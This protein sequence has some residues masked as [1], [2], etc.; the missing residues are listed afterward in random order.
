MDLWSSLLEADTN[1][2]TN[3]VYLARLS[4]SLSGTEPIRIDPEQGEIVKLYRSIHHAIDALSISEDIPTGTKVT[5]FKPKYDISIDTPSIDECPYI[6]ILDEVWT[7]GSFD[8]EVVD[9]YMIIDNRS[10]Q[11]PFDGGVVTESIISKVH[12][13]SSAESSADDSIGSMDDVYESILT[14]FVTE[15]DN[16]DK[17]DEEDDDKTTRDT[18]R[19]ARKDLNDDLGDEEPLDEEQSGEIP[20][21][22]EDGEDTNADDTNT[23]DTADTQDS[24]EGNEEGSDSDAGD[25]DGSGTGDSDSDGMDDDLGDMDESGDSDGGDSSDV[26]S[27]G[28]S[29]DGDSDGTDDGADGESTDGDP[30]ADKNKK[31]N[32]INLLKDFISLYKTIENSNK[33]LTEARKDNI[34]TSVT[35]NQVRKNLTRLG[36][37][38]YNYIL[39]YYDG[40]DHSIN[41]Y[42][43]KYFSEI[44]KLNVDMLRT[45]QNNEDNG[46]TNS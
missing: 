43:F 34:L 4:T 5:V 1:T 27:E 28:D 38:V 45:M 16:D 33:K 23:D 18:M 11:H 44:L 19:D 24:T 41:L 37:V 29:T 2:R 36:E 13:T 30:N 12:D 15:A 8:M 46:Q 25:S 20:K 7:E 22:D 26:D 17:K 6:N 21:D 9:E 14:R 31:I 10:H 42:N 40:N 32:K 39:L 3:D 35:I